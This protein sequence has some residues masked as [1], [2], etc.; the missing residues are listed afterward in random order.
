MQD[1]PDQAAKPKILHE[2]VRYVERGAHRDP[3]ARRQRARVLLRALRKLGYNVEI[4]PIEPAT[5]QPGEG[6]LAVQQGAAAAAEFQKI[7]DYPGVVANE[8]IGALAHLGLG[9]AY[10][11]ETGLSRHGRN[12]GV[13]PPL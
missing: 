3:K 9:R 4:T 8:P 1:L 11:L 10:A 13:K 12:G 6:Y 5:A 2:G 7:L